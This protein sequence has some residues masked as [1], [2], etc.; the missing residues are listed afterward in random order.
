[1]KLVL[2]ARMIRMSGIGRYLRENLKFLASEFDVT[3]LV[4]EHDIAIAQEY[5]VD[6]VIVTSKLFSI[7][8]QVEIVIRSPKCDIFWSPQF[9]VPVLIKIK[10]KHLITTIH[11]ILPIR[12]K[13]GS[14]LR[15]LYSRIFVNIACL[16]SSKII[17]V[18]HFS[19]LEI[20][21]VIRT[22]IKEKIQVIYNGMTY[23]E[24][25]AS[26]NISLPDK[27]ILAVG[28][29]KPHKNIKFLID[30][31]YSIKDIRSDIKLIIVG[32]NSGFFTKD[33]DVRPEL[34]D[35]SIIFTGPVSDA[36]L[37]LLYKNASI[38][39]MPSLYEGFGLPI[40]E[41]MAFKIPILVSAIPVFKELFGDDVSYFE[42]NDK[43]SLV[44]G[45]LTLLET[46]LADNCYE[47]TLA[48]FDWKISANEHYKCFI[49]VNTN[50][51]R[52]D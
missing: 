48:R 45:M 32:K 18:S 12:E 37:H 31:F 1:M 7:H 5:N 9:N 42:P 35:S 2:D 26:G 4:Y 10:A 3:L 17:T 38:Y 6:Y 23:I 21:S 24:P 33:K 11:D 34:R 28:N 41:A 30:S 43:N 15:K 16:V 46:Q 40:L 25:Q 44:E 51:E 36:D 20:Q 8:E 19:K 13:N 52:A 27:Y 47:K 22:M 14:A 39:V 49:N 50:F 29:V